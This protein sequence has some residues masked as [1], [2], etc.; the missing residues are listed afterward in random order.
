M[1]QVQPAAVPGEPHPTL[2]T[3][4][5][6]G[7]VL[8]ALGNDGR[9]RLVAESA[10]GSLIASSLERR[11]PTAARPLPIVVASGNWATPT[12]ALAALDAVVP[13]YR[14]FVLNGQQGLPA[15]AGVIPVTP[16]VG[17]GMRGAR[18]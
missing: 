9:G 17:P 7:H 15:R 2:H 5:P 6:S 18:G 13:S 8:S 14:L 4:P 1:P 16:F 12:V 11:V 3:D 10:L